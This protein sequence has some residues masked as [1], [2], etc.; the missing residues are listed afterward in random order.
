M[1]TEADEVILSGVDAPSR[2]SSLPS[3]DGCKTRRKLLSPMIRN[4]SWLVD[5]GLE[6]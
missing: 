1:S 6:S 5:L 4:G 2:V 3:E